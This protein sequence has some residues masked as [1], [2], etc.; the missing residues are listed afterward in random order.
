MHSRRASGQHQDHQCYGDGRLS[1]WAVGS[2]ER[3]R[4]LSCGRCRAQLPP[5]RLHPNGL[6]AW[7]EVKQRGY[8]GLV[9]KHEASVPI[10]PLAGSLVSADW[11]FLDELVLLV[12]WWRVGLAG[13][14]AEISMI[15]LGRH[16]LEVPR[17][18]GACEA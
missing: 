12:A 6:D 2:S 17:V 16:A 4:R 1:L 11:W 9:A 10:T 8:E 7:A 18:N 15:T 14:L 13:R 5:R 3:K